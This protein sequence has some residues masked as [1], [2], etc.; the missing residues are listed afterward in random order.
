MWGFA[1]PQLA[2]PFARWGRKA[3]D[4]IRQLLILM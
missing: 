4:L 2:K 3:A 1:K